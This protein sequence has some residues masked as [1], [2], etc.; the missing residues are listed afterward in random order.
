MPLPPPANVERPRL[1]EE[2][3]QRLIEQQRQRTARYDE[4]L[5]QQMAVA[6]QRSLALQQ[7]RRLAQ[8][9][10]QEEY[11][12]HLRRQQVGLAGLRAYDY[13]RDPYFYSAPVYRYSRGGQYYDVNQY[14]ADALEQA[15]NYGYQEGF[16]AGRADRE[17]RWRFDYRSSYAYQ[18]ALY[19]YGGLYV[20]P[21]DYEYYFREGFRRGYDDGYYS[22]YRYG[23]NTNGGL[24]IIASVLS[25]ILNLQPLR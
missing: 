3:Q 1:T 25:Q 12:E 5:Q 18:D 16:A 7:Q 20:D 8:Y 14:A 22:R 13:N 10:F 19:G 9:R 11:L 6:Q 23:Y 17:D 21:T 15:V 2:R 4:R 24:N